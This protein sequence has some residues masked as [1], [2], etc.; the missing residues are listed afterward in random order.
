MTHCHGERI[1]SLFGWQLTLHGDRGWILRAG[2][3]A[4]LAGTGWQS[5]MTLPKVLDSA[6]HLSLKS[7]FEQ[8]ETGL[9]F[10]AQDRPE[11]FP[12]ALLAPPEAHFGAL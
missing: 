7:I 6:P 4:A 11:R 5:P 1:Q 2:R 8:G 9:L 3:F 10:Y 12:N